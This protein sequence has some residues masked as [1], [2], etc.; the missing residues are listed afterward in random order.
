MC[1][2]SASTSLP[3]RAR[4]RHNCLKHTAQEKRDVS[5]RVG[6]ICFD[7]TVLESECGCSR[8]RGLGVASR[9]SDKLGLVICH[10]CTYVMLLLSVLILGCNGIGIWKTFWIQHRSF[11]KSDT[12]FAVGKYDSTHRF[13]PCPFFPRL[14]VTWWRSA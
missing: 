2:D 10:V 12:C 5:V 1:W 9:R 7:R 14:L 11:P 13:P 8:G 6:D 3:G 4:R